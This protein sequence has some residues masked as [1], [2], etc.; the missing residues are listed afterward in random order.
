MM[1]LERPPRYGALPV[2]RLCGLLGLSRSAYY[3]QPADA[4]ARSLAEAALLA[5]IEEVVGEDESAGYRRVT[6]QLHRDGLE[7]NHKRVLRLMREEA[8][9][10]RVKRR[11]VATTDSRHG[12]PVWPNLLKGL[13]VTDL[14]QVWVADI[15]Y[16]RL[17]D[18]F[19]YLAAILDACSRR[20]IGFQM[21]RYLDARLVVGALEKALRLRRPPS[22]FIHH[23]D[24]GVQYAC[25]EYVQ[26][27]EQAGARISM[28]GKGRP[29]DNAQMESFFRTLKVEEVYRQEYASILE[30][31]ARIEHFIE[32]VYNRKRLHSALGYRP[33]VEFE[34]KLLIQTTRCP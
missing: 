30:A 19:C 17:P 14:N 21:A 3:A 13:A 20:A 15:T 2:E 27:L 26:R 11:F 18:G 29:R 4:G 8:L 5:H 16:I 25:R 7:V 9:L 22:G 23:S 33:P 31:Q 1:I 34:E 10:C 6:A 28:S 12:W 24:R 32:A